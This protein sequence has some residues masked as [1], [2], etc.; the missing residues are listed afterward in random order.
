VKRCLKIFMKKKKFLVVYDGETSGSVFFV[1]ARSIR[2]V[3]RALTAPCFRVENSDS[4]LIAE[5]DKIG[6]KIPIY[7]LNN[8]QGA[9]RAAIDSSKEWE[10]RRT[11]K[12]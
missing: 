2:D 11:S 3:S 1:L 8:P 6:Y 10:S 5:Y 4:K 12:S 9:L 7:E